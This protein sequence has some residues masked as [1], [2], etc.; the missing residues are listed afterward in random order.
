MT[1]NQ[2]LNR[3]KRQSEVIRNGG[4]NCI[5]FSNYFPVLSN[6][7]PGIVKGTYYSITAFTN[8]GKT[9]FAKDLF[10]NL[11]F[12]EFNRLKGTPNEFKLKILF[13]CLEESKNQFIDSLVCSELYNKYKINIDYN[14]LN[15]LINPLSDDIINKINLITPKLESLFE[16][17]RVE[18]SAS[19]PDSILNTIKSYAYANGKFYLDGEIVDPDTR[20]CVYKPNDPTEHVI[21]VVD[22]IN[23]LGFTDSL[24]KAMYKH[25]KNMLEHCIKRF[26]YSVCDVHQQAAEGENAEYNKFNK[27]ECSLTTLGD[28]KL[29][30]RNYMVVLALDMPQRYGVTEHAGYR[31]REFGNNIDRYRSVKILKNRFGRANIRKGLWFTPNAAMFEELP[32]ASQINYVSYI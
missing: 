32:N 15:S 13:F 11:P 22:H 28:N 24:H 3:Y 21:V 20:H 27:N 17:L 23:I 10:V 19:D 14:Q 1:F 5:P 4:I 7:V 30:A 9:P 12:S 25:S 2:H 16:V 26:N 31:L 8:V 18:D 29:V 6:Y